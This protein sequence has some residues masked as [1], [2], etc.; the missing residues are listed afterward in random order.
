MKEMGANALRTSHNPP[1]AKLL[2]LCDEMGILVIDEAFDMWERSKT[3]YDYA[4]SFRNTKKRTSAAGSE[5][6]GTIPA[7]SCG[8][9]E[10]KYM[11]CTR[12]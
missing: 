6:T 8:P 10:T 11:I 3:E 4:D 5:G 1:A 9:S 2:E 7:L 12:I